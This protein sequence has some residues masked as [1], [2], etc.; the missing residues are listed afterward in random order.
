MKNYIFP[1]FTLFIIGT[2]L[3]S[4][5]FATT[6]DAMFLPQ[7]YVLESL[8]GFGYSNCT[9]VTIPNICNSNPALITDFNN[10]SVG[11]S[12]QFDTNIKPAKWY[13]LTHR[14]IMN[15]FPQSVGFVIPFKNL[16]IGIGAS[17]RY[18]SRLDY[19]KISVTTAEK[20]EG[21]G[22]TFNPIANTY[23]MSYSAVL[24]FSLKN[25]SAGLQYNLNRFYHEA[26]IGILH[27]KVSA[28]TYKSSWSA[29]VKYKLKE[30]ST[31]GFQIGMFYESS[32]RLSG[33]THMQL[34][35]FVSGKRDV[36]LTSKGEIPNKMHFGFLIDPPFPLK[37]TCNLTYWN[38]SKMRSWL[39][40]EGYFKDSFD[41][42]LN[43]IFLVNEKG[44]RH[45]EKGQRNILLSYQNQGMAGG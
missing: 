30:N 18:N 7:G 24:S 11:I 32:L 4:Q 23:L 3:F 9:I 36:L 5:N 27:T 25:F 38:W 16:R 39:Y 22:E 15:G 17:Q 43:F 14:R 20:P 29:G 44:I 28:Y 10:M 8:G 42:A 35:S 34:P 40:T 26:I 45:G 12:Y 6:S 21:T 13:D 33:S 37:F 31:F 1:L 41:L 2:N 19:G